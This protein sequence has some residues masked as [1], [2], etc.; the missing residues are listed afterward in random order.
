MTQG[1]HVKAH[2][3]NMRMVSLEAVLYKNM[4][5]KIACTTVS[6]IPHDIKSTANERE[7]GHEGMLLNLGNC[8]VRLFGPSEHITLWRELVLLS[9]MVS[10]VACRRKGVLGS[11]SEYGVISGNGLPCHQENGMLLAVLAETGSTQF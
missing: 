10:C 1:E 7:Q 6:R 5:C 4:E 3:Q 2:T 9:Y 8:N 11:D